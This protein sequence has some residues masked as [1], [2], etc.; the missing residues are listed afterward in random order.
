M[1]DKRLS[2]VDIERNFFLTA[3][4]VAELTKYHFPSLNIIL[5]HS[6]A[7]KKEQG[8]ILTYNEL[9]PE[10]EYAI[11]CAMNAF[12]ITILALLTIAVGVMIY[13]VCVMLPGMQADQKIYN[14]SQQSAKNQLQAADHRERVSGYGESAEAGGLAGAVS[15]SEEADRL[16]E[17]SVHEAE[18]RAV[19]EEARRK[20][21]NEQL[22]AMEAAAAGPK[23]DG[24][25]GLVTAF[26]QEWL[27]I[28]FKPAVKDVLNEGTVVAVRRE[29]VVLCE[30]TV[31]FLD[32]ESGQVGAT[33][34]PQEFGKT[35]MEVKEDAWLPVVGDEVIYSPFASA[36]D[37]RRENSF[38]T[39]EPLS[40]PSASE[41]VPAE[42]QP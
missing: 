10:V 25:I 5:C 26:N 1:Q 37:L 29:G 28:L 17:S 39:P 3:C 4:S 33:L 22:R 19:I 41:E 9:A 38:L 14:I 40:V 34:R 42:P 12:R 15:E 18:E 31:D 36:R 27:S 16:A 6:S 7:K 21:E 11:L 8:A 24:A 32:E 2:H 23:T 30:A 20:V 13:V 35:Q